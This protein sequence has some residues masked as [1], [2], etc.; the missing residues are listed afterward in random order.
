[1]TQPKRAQTM[2]SLADQIIQLSLQIKAL[3][4]ELEPLKAEF[5]DLM[6]FDSFPHDS[7]F[8]FTRCRRKNW[9]YSPQVEALAKQLKAAQRKE[10]QTEL[11]S[12]EETEFLQVRMP[13]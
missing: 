5:L 6:M 13:K 8:T 12:Y 4:S 1:M 3:Q 11:A 7:G 9:S 10:Q 2:Q